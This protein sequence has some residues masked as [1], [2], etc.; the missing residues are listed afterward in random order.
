MQVLSGIEVTKFWLLILSG[1]YLIV[2]VKVASSIFVNQLNATKLSSSSSLN[3]AWPSPV[4]ACFVYLG[5]YVGLYL[6]V[7]LCSPMSVSQSLSLSL[8][9]CLPARGQRNMSLTLSLRPCF[10]VPISLSLFPSLLPSLSLSVKVDSTL[11]VEWRF[12]CDFLVSSLVGF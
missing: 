3:W 12:G 7:F 11:T 5:L 6:S 9:S 2:A 8:C 4:P 10:S 1:G